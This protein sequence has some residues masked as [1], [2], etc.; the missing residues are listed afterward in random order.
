MSDSLHQAEAGSGRETGAAEVRV[1]SASE[2]ARVIR[3]SVRGVRRTLAAIP[4]V[5]APGG[6]QAWPFDSLPAEMQQLL[7]Q[8]ARRQG[9]SG[10]RA[11]LGADRTTL[12]WQP[13]CAIVECA[14]TV[15]EEAQRLRRAL[16]RAIARRNETGLSGADLLAIGLEDY[17]RE[18][19]RPIV[20]RHWRRLFRRTLDRA[21]THWPIDALE[22]YLPER[23][24]R[25]GASAQ[26]VPAAFRN[27]EFAAVAEIFNRWVVPSRPTVAER[28]LFW[29]EACLWQANEIASGRPQRAV[30]EELGDFLWARLAGFFRTRE[31]VRKA[32]ARKWDAWADS[33]KIDSLIDRRPE[34]NAARAKVIPENLLHRVVYTSLRKFRGDL[35]PAAR[36]VFGGKL[37]ARKSYVPATLRNQAAPLIRALAPFHQGPRAADKAA[38]SLNLSYDGNRSMDCLSID[39]VTLNSYFWHENPDG[40]FAVTRGQM[41]LIIDVRSLRVLQYGMIPEEQ[42]NSLLAWGVTTRAIAEFGIPRKLQVER[43]K[44]FRESAL[45]TGGRNSLRR[46]MSDGWED[47]PTAE[48]ELGL[49]RL[50]II[51]TTA[52]RARSK[53]VERVIGLVQ[54]LMDGEVGFAGRFERLDL[55]EATARALAAVARGPDEISPDRPHP[56]AYFFRFDQWEARVA[57]I[58]GEYNRTPQEGKRLRGLTP[59]EAF[60]QFWRDEDPPTRLDDRTRHLLAYHRKPLVVRGGAVAF[61]LR[62]EIFSYRHE[63]LSRHEGQTLLGW[64]EPEN[65]D[66]ITVTDMK[67][68]NPLTVERDAHPNADVANN[69]GD[70]V[71][72]RE[73]AK[74]QRHQRFLGTLHRTMKA[75]F[76]PKFRQVVTPISEARIGAEIEAQRVQ[77]RDQTEASRRNEERG[78]RRLR[79]L[80]LSPQTVSP[81]ADLDQESKRLM[82]SLRQLQSKEQKEREAQ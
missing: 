27:E 23:P 39:D 1:F 9:F 4:C 28:A 60:R 63:A 34:S 74:I 40:T 5:V 62:G 65:M 32:I 73:T 13:P 77:V 30:R 33:A 25:W 82:D 26:P 70:E 14:G 2:I 68:G 55:P 7:E 36:E 76:G 54:D 57:D 79:D 29:N 16:A 61:R 41:I 45:M 72:R 59:D 42:P 47:V 35:A 17:R 22:I 71:L 51:F 24:T 43:G 3:G 66:V 56:S 44:V 69:G 53:P 19:G 6:R 64:L 11:L 50:G 67:R 75:Q 46:E 80:G 49:Q 38:P 52:R 20:E 8:E 15:Q 18:F 78:A 21:G 58:I 48:R 37:G 81:A 12:P 10:G 31:A